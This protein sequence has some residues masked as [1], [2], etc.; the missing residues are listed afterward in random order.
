MDYI[1]G[2]RVPWGTR[3]MFGGGNRTRAL[4]A[5]REAAQ[6]SGDFYTEVE[7]DFALWEMLS[8]DKKMAEAVAVA[9]ELQVRFPEN[10]DLPRFIEQNAGRK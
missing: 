3:W 5:V 1:V 7:A 2:T 4:Q 9:K 10:P 8:R 6:V